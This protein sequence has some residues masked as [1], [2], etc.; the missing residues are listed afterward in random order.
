MKD[1][2][3]DNVSAEKTLE[4]I[5]EVQNEYREK[6]DALKQQGIEYLEKHSD[7]FGRMSASDTNYFSEH[8]DKPLNNLVEDNRQAIEAILSEPASKPIITPLTNFG[9]LEKMAYGN[10]VNATDEY[11]N[12]FLGAI[13]DN[14][15]HV[16][17]YLSEGVDANGGYLC[18]VEL[19]KEITKALEEK[20]VLREMSTVINTASKH[21]LPIVSSKPTAY[22]VTEGAEINL[23]DES[24]S[25]VTLDAHKLAVGVK[26]TNELVADSAYNLEDFFAQQFGEI[27]GNAEEDAFINGAASSDTQNQPTGFLTTLSNLT[28]SYITT[29]TT[30]TAISV[31][32]L[33]NLEYSVNRAYRKNASWLMNDATLQKIRQLKNANLDFI[34]TPSMVEGEPDKLFGR[35]VYT[36]SFFPA[37]DT[38]GDIAVA[39][40]DFSRYIIA[41]RGT[42]IFKPL[43]EVYAL[44]DMTAFLLIER[45]DGKLVDTQ[46]IKLLK[47]K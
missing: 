32:D 23:T 6:I 24:F 9:G 46:A 17:N 10:K 43:R 4:K 37:A 33:V 15:Q 26:V 31:D 28:D 29:A 27:L 1:L 12:A 18:P 45:V 30:D 36:S 16:D 3:G 39:F 44:S 42:R 7:Q 2:I 11:R 14:F 47:L 22:W 25:Q 19:D 13:R 20:N 34:W 35:P 5:I 40:G 21:Q 41:D 38:R 8:Y